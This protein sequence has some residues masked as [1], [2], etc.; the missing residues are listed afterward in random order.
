MVGEP[1]LQAGF[2]GFWSA[3]SWRSATRLSLSNPHISVNNKPHNIWSVSAKSVVVPCV[4]F[5][6]VVVIAELAAAYSNYAVYMK[7]DPSLGASEVTSK[8]GFVI[9]I[10]GAISHSTAMAFERSLAANPKANLVHL[11]SSG[12]VLRAA[13][14]LMD[15]IR[16]RGLTTIVTGTCAS[17]CVL[18][19]V[20][21]K[22]RLISIDAKLGFHSASAGPTI[23]G[24][25]IPLFVGLLVGP[26][27]DLQHWQR[28]I[29]IHRENTSIRLSYFFGGSIFFLLLLFHGCLALWVMNKDGAPLSATVALD[30]FKY[31]P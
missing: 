26:W 23:Y 15:T 2:L 3:S 18:V 13:A 30:G 7:G 24:Y 16:V 11:D 8:D 10:R 4:I 5:G 9:E 27:L 6:I 31:A 22:E 29:Q 12:G 25:A 20:S 28:A 1:I 17:A 14:E 21:G 19:F